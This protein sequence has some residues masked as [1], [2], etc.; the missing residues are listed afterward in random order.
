MEIM[1]PRR[2]QIFC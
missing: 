2:L 1:Q